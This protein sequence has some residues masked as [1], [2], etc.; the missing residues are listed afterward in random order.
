MGKINLRELMEVAS[1]TEA[2][3]YATAKRS[4]P[5]AYLLEQHGTA[6]TVVSADR[7]TFLCPFH[8][9][10]NSPAGSV[11]GAHLEHW[12]C[13]SCGAKGD[14]IDMLIRY[15]PELVT[16]DDDG[17]MKHT[18]A[19]YRRVRELIT[20]VVNAGWTG[21]SGTG[22]ERPAF[23]VK[24]AQ[25]IVDAAQ[26][27]PN[28][29]HIKTFIDFKREQRGHAA[30]PYTTDYLVD[31]WGVGTWGS[32]VII[33]YYTADGSLLSY[34]RWTD[35]AR[36]RFTHGAG[37]WAGHLY[38][39]HRPDT[40][41]D[42]IIVEGESD[43]WYTHYRVGDRYR[44]L[45]VATGAASSVVVDGMNDRNVLLAFDGDDAGVEAT[46]R[47]AEALEEAGANVRILPIPQG[48]D[49]STAGDINS[50]IEQAQPLVRPPGGIRPTP[51][52][53][54][55]SSGKGEVTTISNWVFVPKRAL[56][57]DGT[58]AFEGILKPGGDSAVIRTTDLASDTKLV[59]WAGRYGRAWMGT[60]NDSR[61]LLAL[62]QYEA[63]F[64]P[65]GYLVS[66]A[67]LHTDTFVW[68]GGRVGPSPV[69]YVPPVAD[70][71]LENKIHI[72]PAKWDT[73]LVHTLR[74]VQNH[75]VTD[76]LLAWL[77]AATLRSIM[78]GMK[79]PFVGVSG[80]FGAGKTE[81]TRL[82]VQVF[83]GSQLEQTF[84]STPHAIR[85]AMSSTNALPVLIGERRKGA[86]ADSLEAGDQ[87]LRQA[88]NMQV[89]QQGGMGQN[90]W[91]ELTDTIPSA[92]IVIEG[93]DMFS[94]GSH[95]ERVV[96][97]HFKEEGKNPEA[98]ERLMLNAFN[99]RT[100]VP[101]TGLPYAYLTYVQS[102]L[103]SGVFEDLTI[104]PQ[105]PKNLAD[106]QRYTLGVLR[107][108]WGL[109]Q[110]FMS[111]YNDNLSDPNFDGIIQRYQ[112]ANRR[113]PVEDALRFCLGNAE[114]RTFI[115]IADGEVW[116]DVPMMFSFLADSRRSMLFTLPGK[117]PFLKSH[118]ETK[119]GARY[120]IR[121]FREYMVFPLSRIVE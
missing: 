64:L 109:L 77:S 9:N 90:S 117:V 73:E 81:T 115:G 45:G 6:V 112:E 19:L 75:D 54:T 44:V 71:H 100:G 119:F 21:P 65:T 84:L 5:I 49:I 34:K 25:E 78:P 26:N 20:E 47:W 110:S 97:L 11:F 118:L 29:T 18:A 30:W 80:D 33:P 76:P 8:E 96:P 89:S 35:P 14:A 32:W 95:V 17:K 46:R 68:P 105:G 61:K 103:A 27:D 121:D 4:L 66:I 86:R 28:H 13:W 83:S 48:L 40:G 37:I 94:E 2:V 24:E 52:G 88:W 36:R 87:L 101:T 63:V 92:P 43:C 16:H 67:G 102:L 107:F 72:K 74:D 56:R 93:E 22:V 50:L 10:N 120:A 58:L 79:F 62:L 15:E 39:E 85:S 70:G 111:E 104:A 116:V 113:T 51:A 31:E 99:M 41:Q 60:S 98:F 55:R 108:G 3:D 59:A 114:A 1:A 91:A 57:G 106:R 42:I 38:G 7:L 69:V 82:M 12:S 23:D 53:Y